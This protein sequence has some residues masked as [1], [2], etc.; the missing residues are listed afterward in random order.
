M[1]ENAYLTAE[2]RARVQIDRQPE[3]CGWVVQD[4]SAKNLYAGQGVAVREFI[5]AGGHGR[6][7]RLLAIRRPEGDRSDRGEAVG[8]TAG[9]RG[10]AVGEY[11]TGLPRDLPA[12][13]SPL[14]FLPA[15][16]WT[17]ERL[18]AAPTGRC[19]LTK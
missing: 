5:M 7:G 9:R 15:Y 4:R 3:A 10:A 14:P 19:A 13:V 2:A 12:L 17:P 6:P 18:W 16:N 1:S 8:D 11:S